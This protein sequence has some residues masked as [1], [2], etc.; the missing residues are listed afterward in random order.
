MAQ[1]F[2]IAIGDYCTPILTIHM[3]GI[4]LFQQLETRTVLVECT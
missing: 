3:L 4:Q 2:E 1:N